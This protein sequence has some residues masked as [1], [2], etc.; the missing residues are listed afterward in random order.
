VIARVRFGEPIAPRAAETDAAVAERAR[1]A[2]AAL[3]A[4]SI[5]GE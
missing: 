5:Y 2:I 3:N 1:H 4:A